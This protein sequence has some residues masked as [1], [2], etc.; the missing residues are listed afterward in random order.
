M[1]ANDT[2]VSKRAAQRPKWAVTK[3]NLVGKSERESNNTEETSDILIQRELQWLVIGI[4]CVIMGSNFYVLGGNFSRCWH[5]C[6]FTTSFVQFYVSQTNSPPNTLRA[7]PTLVWAILQMMV[8]RWRCCSTSH[9]G[10][11]A[12]P[13][14]LIRK[15]D[16]M[17]SQFNVTRFLQYGV[18]LLPH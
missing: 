10:L 16:D 13:K 5:L 2:V 18:F 12:I 8:M 1:F 14:S 3:T 6:W 4:A 11:C 9:T 17:A 7:H 15:R